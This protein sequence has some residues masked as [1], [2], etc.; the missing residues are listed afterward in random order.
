MNDPVT[1]TLTIERS[2]A[3]RLEVAAEKYEVPRGEIANTLLDVA[4]EIDEGRRDYVPRKVREAMPR[5]NGGSSISL[6]EGRVF[7]RTERL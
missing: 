5:R 4:L 2:V 6:P 3:E 1:L 7:D